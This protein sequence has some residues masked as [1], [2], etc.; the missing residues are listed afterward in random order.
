MLIRRGV[1]DSGIRNRNAQVILDPTYVWITKLPTSPG[2]K[3]VPGMK[4]GMVIP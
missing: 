2:I 4:P 3:P 1:A